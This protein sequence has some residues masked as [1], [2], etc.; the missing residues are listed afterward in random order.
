MVT[1]MM[2]SDRIIIGDE[3]LMHYCE[4]ESKWQSMEW[5]KS[6][7]ARSSKGNHP[8]KKFQFRSTGTG[9]LSEEEHKNKEYS[10]Q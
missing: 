3:T 8:Q 10:L 5:T 9:M 2:P 6:C 1:N 7:P 4:P